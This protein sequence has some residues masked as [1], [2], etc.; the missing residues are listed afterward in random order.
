MR[1]YTVILRVRC[2][3]SRDMLRKLIVWETSTIDEVVEVEVQESMPPFTQG[4]VI[5]P[6]VKE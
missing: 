6:Q 3:M 2:D 5:L 1:E 4:E